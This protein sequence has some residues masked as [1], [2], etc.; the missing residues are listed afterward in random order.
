MQYAIAVD[1]LIFV[2][3]YC[4]ATLDNVYAVVYNYAVAPH[5]YCAERISGV[6]FTDWKVA[7]ATTAE[8]EQ[9]QK[10]YCTFHCFTSLLLVPKNISASIFL[11]R[12]RPGSLFFLP[13]ALP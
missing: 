13:S 7:A 11:R 6:V 5:G 3:E 1:V 4:V 9:Q 12:T 2:L 10:N 8:D